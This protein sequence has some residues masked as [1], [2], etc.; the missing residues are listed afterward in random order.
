M[1]NISVKL[2]YQ[3]MTIFFYFSPFTSHLIHY[4]SKIAAAI[5]GLYSGW[6]DNG[7]YSDAKGLN[8]LPG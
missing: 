8:M 1:M 6:D 5:R 7:K 3:Y 2:F 4:K